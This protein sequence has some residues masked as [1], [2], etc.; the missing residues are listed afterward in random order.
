MAKQVNDLLIC[1]F[2]FDYNNSSFY[3]FES[4]EKKEQT[5][6]NVSK[7]LSNLILNYFMDGIPPFLEYNPLLEKDKNQLRGFD[8]IPI[9]NM[10]SD[11]LINGSFFQEKENLVKS[12]EK[13]FKKFQKTQKIKQ[14]TK[15]FTIGGNHL[16][17]YFMVREL[18]LKYNKKLS[19]I[20]FD[21]HHDLWDETPVGE[22]FTNGTW[23]RR[24]IEDGYVDPT[25]TVLLGIRSVY[26]KESKNFYMENG[27]KVFH[28]TTLQKITIQSLLSQILNTV[29]KDFCYLSFDLDFFDP[30]VA[31]AVRF[32]EFNGFNHSYIFDILSNLTNKWSMTNINFVGYDFVEYIP[33]LDTKNKISGVSLITVIFW[34]LCYEYFSMCNKKNRE[35]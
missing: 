2:P 35:K 23:L 27:V 29:D 20:V 22:K 10:I 34:F 14:N 4:L 15:L 3:S 21:A 11:N 33:E 5:S 25:K 12:F 18:S 7:I 24:A 13:S 16:L 26:T 31:G 32:P 6:E 30:S 19:L 1:Y 28:N 8:N 9:I 17:S